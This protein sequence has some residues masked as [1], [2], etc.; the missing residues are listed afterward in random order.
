MVDRVI[1]NTFVRPLQILSAHARW[2]VDCGPVTA[3]VVM[4]TTEVSGIVDND[5][6]W[7]PA[8][9][10]GYPIELSEFHTVPKRPKLRYT[11]AFYIS[12]V[13]EALNDW[14]FAGT[15]VEWLYGADI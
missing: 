1:N 2:E 13:G 14:H 3:M 15:H 11:A 7:V 6:V 9:I 10:S 12:A 8:G 5:V 4:S